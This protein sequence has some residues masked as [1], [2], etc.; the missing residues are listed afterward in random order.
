MELCYEVTSMRGERGRGGGRSA[1]AGA[2]QRGCQGPPT[3]AAAPCPPPP[4]VLWMVLGA[5]LLLWSHVIWLIVLLLSLW[6]FMELRLI[7][8]GSPPPGDGDG[9]GDGSAD[10][11]TPLPLASGSDEEA[12]G[13]QLGKGAA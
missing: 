10:A 6:R 5:M 4:A 7:E 12:G 11:G 9:D 3:L 13:G 1:T 8:G 2:R